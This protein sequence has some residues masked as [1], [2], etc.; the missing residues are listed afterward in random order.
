MSVKMKVEETEMNRNA[1]VKSLGNVYIESFQ[2]SAEAFTL[3]GRYAAL[4]S[5]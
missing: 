3:L 1:D 2:A 4:V 5:S